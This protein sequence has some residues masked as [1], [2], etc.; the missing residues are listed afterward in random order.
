MLSDYLWSRQLD[1]HLDR[2]PY[3]ALVMLLM[4]RSDSDNLAA[5]ARAFP[6][7][8]QELQERYDAPAGVLE[9]DHLTV[10]QALELGDRIQQ[11]A[12]GIFTP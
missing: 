5:L 11:M 2:I 1:S 7:V 4:R 6:A 3:F 12:A 9:S 10:E 8:F